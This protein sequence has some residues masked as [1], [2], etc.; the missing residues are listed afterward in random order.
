[1][2]SV[3]FTKNCPNDQVTSNTAPA[4]SHATGVAV[5]PALFFFTPHLTPSKVRGADELEAIGFVDVGAEILSM[6]WTPPHFKKNALLL[7]CAKGV[8]VELLLPK[9]D[10]ENHVDHCLC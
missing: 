7:C 9:D 5:Y 10:L 4:H 6:I 1:M 8:L 2:P 3:A